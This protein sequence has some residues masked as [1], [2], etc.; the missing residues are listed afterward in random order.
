MPTQQLVGAAAALVWASSCAHA[1]SSATALP[2]S[3]LQ[4]WSGCREGGL[5][6]VGLQLCSAR[7]RPPCPVTHF[8]IPGFLVCFSSCLHQESQPQQ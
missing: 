4:V 6:S 8:P 7:A 5:E 1:G 3:V 2:G